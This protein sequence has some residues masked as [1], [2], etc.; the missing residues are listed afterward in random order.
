[1]EDLIAL[2]AASFARYGIECPAMNMDND[3]KVVEKRASS[4]V[5]ADPAALPEHNFRKG[6]QGDPAP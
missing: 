5:P 3:R 4:P 6:L 2:V 1:M